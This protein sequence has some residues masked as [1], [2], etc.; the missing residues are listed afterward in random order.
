MSFSKQDHEY[1]ALAMAEANAALDDGTYPVGAVLTINNEF[2]GKAR[3]SVFLEEQSTA[4][5]EMNLL[6]EHSPLL[7]RSICENPDA[8]I[9]VYTTLEP[10]LMCLGSIAIHRVSRIVSACPD[11]HGGAGFLDV[12]KIGSFY[13]DNWPVM[14]TGLMRDE[15]ADL[16]IDFFKQKKVILWEVALKR[17]TKMKKG[18]V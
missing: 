6:R 8:I 15:S 16:M 3:N 12:E 18:W 5:A 2:I 11:P 1:M 4:H 14:E 9:T 10:C 17:F 7:R 13:G